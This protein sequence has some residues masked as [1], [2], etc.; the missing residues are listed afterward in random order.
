MKDEERNYCVYMHTNKVNGKKYIG[1]T[2]QN[3]PE[4]RWGANGRKYKDNDHWVSAIRQ[5][6]WDNFYHD[7]LFAGL[8]KKEA[9]QKEVELIAHYDSTNRE[10]GYNIQNGGHSVGVFTDETKKKMSESHKNIDMPW[11]KSAIWQYSLDGEFIEE[12][13]SIAAVIRKYGFRSSSSISKCCNGLL[14]KAYGYI[15]RYAGDP[16]TEEHRLWC[17]SKDYNPSNKKG[18]VRYDMNGVFIKEYE[19]TLSAEKETGADH[20]VIIRCCNNQCKTSAG[21]IWRYSGDE[22][23]QEHIEWCNSNA[24]KPSIRKAVIQLTLDYMFVDRY[25]S[26]IEA[27]NITGVNRSNISLC[28]NGKQKTAGGYIWIFESDFDKYIDVIKVGDLCA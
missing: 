11:T 5:Y 3:P 25:V 28:C 26:T 9:E 12:F 10:F 7:I 14:K 24:P 20:S 21:S 13:E 17:I 2:G 8:T 15:W 23:T 4:K 6:G 22:L 18:V 1:I 19:S 16:L 27:E